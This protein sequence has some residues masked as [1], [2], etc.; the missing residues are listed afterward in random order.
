[1]I[2]ENQ[3]DFSGNFSDRQHLVEAFNIINSLVLQTF[4]E[5][6]L[7]TSTFLGVRDPV[8]NKTNGNPSS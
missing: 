2:T 8:V 1:M 5:Q 7:C 6:L 3:R 4:I